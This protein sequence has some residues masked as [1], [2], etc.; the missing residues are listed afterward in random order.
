[1]P[2]TENDIKLLQ[3]ARMTDTPNGGGRMTGNVVQSGVDNNIFDDVSNL[4]RVYGN[5][6]LRKVFPA[7][8][9][10]TTDKYL[11]SRV[12]IDEPPA[13]AN[14]DV[15]LFGA[16]S[17]FD[18][19]DEAK[20]RLEAYL[21]SGAPYQGLLYGPH[22]AGMMTILLFQQLDRDVPA[23]GDTLLLRKEVLGV[24]TEQY[25]RVTSVTSE[26]LTFTDDKGDYTRRVV[27]CGIGD[28]LRYDCEGWEPQRSD[29]GLTY[30][31]RARPFTTRVANAAQYYG[32]RP[33]AAAASVGAYNIK[34]DSAYSALVPSAQIETPLIDLNGA[35]TNVGYARTGTT[36]A[37]AS[38]TPFTT[39]V[40]LSLGA[41][42]APGT[43]QLVLPSAN[44]ITDTG[45]GVLVVGGVDVG[46]VD[47]ENGIAVLSNALYNTTSGSIQVSYQLGGATPLS[48]QSDYIP[49][50]TE[51]RSLTYV[52]SL[53]TKPAAG[54]LSISYL[55]GGKWYV[56]RDRG[57]GIM[58]GLS[59]GLGAG[60]VNFTTRSVTMTL[61]ALPDVGSHVILQWGREESF[62]TTTPVGSDTNT[63]K[64][65]FSTPVLFGE[66]TADL[67][68]SW[69]D[70]AAKSFGWTDGG[71][72][73]GSGGTFRAQGLNVVGIEFDVL[74]PKGTTITATGNT[75]TTSSDTYNAADT[76][77]FTLPAPPLRGSVQIPVSIV[78]VFSVSDWN[79][80]QTVMS[81]HQPG[82]TITWSNDNQTVA[83]TFGVTLV[84][85]GGVLQCSEYEGQKP[86]ARGQLAL[87]TVDYTTGAVTISAAPHIHGAAWSGPSVFGWKT[88]GEGLG[89]EWVN[90]QGTRSGT[91]TVA[92]QSATATYRTGALVPFSCTWPL[93]ELR[94]GVRGVPVGNTLAS[95]TFK[96]G[97][98]VYRRSVADPTKLLLNPSPLTGEGTEVGM[99]FATA[100]V[101]TAWPALA[102]NTV[103]E[104]SAVSS[105]TTSASADVYVAD[106]MVFR[107]PNAPLR[108]GSFTV[109]GRLIDYAGGTPTPFSVTADEN[110]MINTANLVGFVEYS[111]GICHL[112]ARASGAEAVSLPQIP[113]PAW[114]TPVVTGGFPAEWKPGLLVTSSVSYNAVS[115]SYLPLDANI[116]GLDPVR[117]PSDGRVPIFKAGR[118]VVV[119]NTVKMPPATVS[120]GQTVNCGR[121]LLSRIR[122]FGNDGLEITSG[123]TKN[124]DA[125]TITFTNVAGYSQPVTIEHRIEDEALCADAQITGDLR[126]SRPLTHAYPATTSYVSSA[127]IAGTLQAAAQ[128]AFAQ[129]T[130]TD[131][132]SDSRIGTPILAQYN[133][134]ANPLVVTNAG[135]ITERWALIF[136][137]NTTFN[138]VGE[139][140]GQIITG[141][142]ATTLAPVNPA[143][144]VPYFT[145][146]PA[147]WGSGWVAGN[148]L[149]FNTAGANF[150]LWVARTVRQSPSAPP[151]TDQMT[152]SIRG[153]IDQ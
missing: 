20:S 45:Y 46:A 24:E 33:L 8:L 120:N 73:T 75:R 62:T 30:D 59:E 112:F 144:G 6:S 70:G 42:V 136:T 51:G 87:G 103:T 109:Q 118:V 12:I 138:V 95:L 85:A 69:N 97:T 77:S 72:P 14:I 58:K 96:M 29:S 151:G 121:T 129:T 90:F 74:P 16:S 132:W 128:D 5:V 19:R 123:F 148:V 142:T 52:A 92:A 79:G 133:D 102:A 135:A 146:A 48:L 89:S 55:V 131:V 60:S 18:T 17:L 149:R 117:L 83:I 27:A 127:Y 80:F 141:D 40:N 126:L 68:V 82:A 124:L 145:L 101:L 37:Y 115:Y 35:G 130:W 4:D 28:A 66:Y 43:L 26:D 106:R 65:V 93:D 13:D 67:S 116:L 84:D 107:T 147:G 11:G 32:I 105:K 98:N 9:T 104:F 53:S 134:T 34:A 10:T 2:I 99:V 143:T 23:I 1:M 47:Y 153:D 57:D 81:V 125:G 64:L 36:I 91:T 150:P 38:A 56:I 108:P 61:G 21:T 3:S 71:A 31:T 49:V 100:A 140:V 50:T 114:L 113:R 152:I 15:T 122:V 139:E 119:H 41:C 137:S 44:T 94:V 25:V 88:T 86:Y 54:T 39:T 110:G 78:Q 111:T 76:T 63:A 22:I 7:V